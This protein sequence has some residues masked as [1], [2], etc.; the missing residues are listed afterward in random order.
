[1][2]PLSGGR[3]H[4]TGGGAALSALATPVLP[5]LP[6]HAAAMPTRVRPPFGGEVGK[7][8]KEKVG[9]LEGGK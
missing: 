1:M 6:F 2:H 8:Q 3:L 9:Q 4:V 7:V 5:S